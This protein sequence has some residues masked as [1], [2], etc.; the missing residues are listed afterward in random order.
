MFRVN[1]K[2]GQ[3]VAIVLKKDQ[4][5]GKRTRGKVKWILTSAPFHSRG[6]KVILENRQIGRVQEIITDDQPVRNTTLTE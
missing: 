2:L 6:I 5:T 1:I 4:R 3:E